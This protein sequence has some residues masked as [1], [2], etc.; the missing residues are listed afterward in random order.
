VARSPKEEQIMIGGADGVPQIY[1]I[2]RTTARKIGDNSNL[3]RRFPPMDGRVYSVAFAP[4]GLHCAAGASL[5]DVGEIDILE[6]VKDEGP[7]A[8]LIKIM[9]KTVLTQTAAEQKQLNDYF[10]STSK[11][12][13][14]LKVPGGVYSLAWNPDGKTIAAAGEDGKLRFIDAAQGKVVKE[15]VPVPLVNNQVAEV[16]H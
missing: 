13:H 6:S 2:F 12:L 1:R 11:Q 16:K 3:L 4:D 8:D 14:R 15:F 9:T 7:S 5:D 10:E